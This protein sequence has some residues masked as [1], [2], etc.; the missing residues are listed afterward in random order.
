[1]W[2]ENRSAGSLSYDTDAGD[3]PKE[4]YSADDLQEETTVDFDIV[5]SDGHSWGRP[6]L[7]TLVDAYSRGRVATHVTFESRENTDGL[8][9]SSRSERQSVRLTS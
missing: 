3:D 8:P 4:Q 2:V 7:P 9:E 5:E 1:M 6:M